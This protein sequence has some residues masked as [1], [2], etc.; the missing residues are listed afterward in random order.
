MSNEYK[1]WI[2][3]FND[4]QK[5][6]YKLCMK[7]PILIPHNRWTGKIPDDYMYEY[8]E[9]DGMPDGWRIAFGEQWASD[10]QT[11]INKLPEDK[12]ESVRIMDVKEKYGFLHTYFSYYPR[13]LNDVIKKYKRLSERTCIRCGAPATKISQG[14]ISPYCDDC[15]EKIPYDMVDINEWL[16]EEYNE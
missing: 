4:D 7:Y 9:L 2:D 11:A 3:D 15:A 5:K 1:D 13:E 12:R 14:W 8:T 6:N 10:V 16:E